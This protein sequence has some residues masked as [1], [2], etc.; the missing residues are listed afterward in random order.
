MTL[1]P[2][3]QVKL[4]VTVPDII[5]LCVGHFLTSFAGAQGLMI[6]KFLRG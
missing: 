1:K 5:N 4:M 2:W 6:M 3:A